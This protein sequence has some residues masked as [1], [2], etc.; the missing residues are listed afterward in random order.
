MQW[1]NGAISKNRSCVDF[2]AINQEKKPT[3]REKEQY[4]P[5]RTVNHAE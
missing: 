1:I 3:H 2:I 4:V 5:G